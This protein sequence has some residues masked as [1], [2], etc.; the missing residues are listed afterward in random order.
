MPLLKSWAECLEQTPRGSIVAIS[1]SGQ[2]PL[3]S[4]GNEHAREMRESLAKLVGETNPAAVLIYFTDFGYEWG[5]GICE[6]IL[7]LRTSSN[8]LRPGC[9][10]SA[11]PF[12][13][14]AT[15]K[16]ADALTPLVS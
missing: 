4:L 12:C 7:P 5:D 11:R 2:Y 8:T 16:T 1:F 9:H 6:L 10:F 13:F 15:G 14:V 3:G